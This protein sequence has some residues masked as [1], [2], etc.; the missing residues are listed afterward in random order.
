MNLFHKQ[1]STH[2]KRR[3]ESN[4]KTYKMDIM[5]NLILT[6]FLVGLIY[7]IG[8]CQGPTLYNY[9][10]VPKVNATESTLKADT[11]G[12]NFINTGTNYLWDYSTLNVT[13]DKWDANFVDPDLTT[14]SS[15]FPNATIASGASTA[16][17][18]FYGDT[19]EYIS[20]GRGFSGA[21]IV[22]SNPDKLFT[23]PFSHGNQMT[24]SFYATYILNSKTHQISG[25]RI[26]HADGWGILKLP[27]N[28]YNNVLRIN[29]ELYYK[30]ST[31]GEKTEYLSSFCSWYDGIHTQ[32][33]MLISLDKT[34]S[35]GN[36]TPTLSKSAEVADFTEIISINPLESSSSI[37]I[38]PNPA[39]KEFHIEINLKRQVTVDISL[40]DLLGN[41]VRT[42]DIKESGLGKYNNTIDIS[43]LPKGIYAVRIKTGQEVQVKRIVIQ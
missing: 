29:T 24:D 9:N 27:K 33:L 30:D 10:I 4:F 34:Y 41:T 43:E 20:L 32:Y 17:S 36:P 3:H 2:W 7:N 22:Y 35:N 12:V 5:K 8:L 14:Y 39:H 31:F 23:F 11:T 25:Y 28:T 21:V 40:L 13:T 16:W 42:I 37:I 15:Y 18:Y 19:N 1:V 26:I 38:Y 6:A